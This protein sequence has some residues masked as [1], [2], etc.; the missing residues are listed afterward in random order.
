MHSTRRGFLKNSLALSGT[1]ALSALSDSADSAPLSSDPQSK[2]TSSAQLLF[3]G[4]ICTL[5]DHNNVFPDGILWVSGNK[6]RSAVPSVAALPPA[7]RKLPII[8]TGG[9]FYPGLIDLHKHITYDIH[10]PWFSQSRFT[11]RTELFLDSDYLRT[12]ENPCRMLV[13]YADLLDE[14]CLYAEVKALAGG[15]TSLQG[16]APWSRAYTSLLV[17]NIEFENFGQDRIHQT[18]WDVTPESAQ[19]LRELMPHLDA[20]IYHL[21]EG[22]GDYGQQRFS[23]LKQFQL[24]NNKLVAIHALGLNEEEFV[25][26]AAAGASVVW[27]PLGNLRLYGTT[28]DIRAAVKAGVNLCIGSEWA[29]SGSKNLLFDLKVVDQINQKQLNNLLSDLQIVEMIT[30]NAS[31]AIS[32]NDRVGRLAPEMIADVLLLQKRHKDPYR[33]L[34]EATEQDVSLVLIDGAPVYGDLN[35]MNRFHSEHTDVLR[36]RRGNPKALAWNNSTDMGWPS[37]SAITSRI[38]SAL[39]MEPSSLL[40]SLSRVKVRRALSPS[41]PPVQQEYPF[42]L[43]IGDEPL[44]LEE[45]SRFI[46][47]VFPAGV[48][49]FDLDP[50]FVSDDPVALRVMQEPVLAANGLDIAHYFTP[51][52]P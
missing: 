41:A 27:S 40:T 12:V 23:D 26:L 15:T 13:Q 14:V 42:F 46:S 36:P 24:L 35:L 50:I 2:N 16:A 33:N 18:I 34:I 10:G 3:R 7:A 44:E 30:R 39:S 48:S 45:I 1:V 22:I 31:K 4:T 11:N 38:S 32:W 37:L 5:D 51:I 28:T 20:W 49:S 19:A 6:I 43:T 8:N 52:L 29:P 9:I 47:K 17:R 25:E 21:S